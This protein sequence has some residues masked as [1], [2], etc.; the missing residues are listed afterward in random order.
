MNVDNPR[1]PCSRSIP[2]FLSNTPLGLVFGLALALGVPAGCAQ[3]APS[4]IDEATGQRVI[5]VSSV[6]QLQDALQTVEGPTR[7]LIEPGR[8]G[9]VEL[10]NIAAAGGDIEIA[11]ADPDRRAL[12]AGLQLRN[13]SGLT[14][15]DIDL[16]RHSNHAREGRYLLLLVSSED[17]TIEGLEFRGLNQRID[18]SI[19]AAAMLRSSSNVVFAKNS[20]SY[21]RHGLEM[22][23]LEN[24]A[25][26]FNEFTHMQ[27]DAIRGGGVNNSLLANNVMTEFYPAEGDHP[28]GIQL[29]STNQSEPG[30]NIVIRDNLLVKG[31]GGYAQ[32]IFI[33]DTTDVL[34]FENIEILDNLMIGSLYHGINIT[35][36]TGARIA[37]NEIIAV[38][39]Q[40][41]WIRVNYGNDV[42]MEDNRAESFLV[43]NKRGSVREARNRQTSPSNRN[44]PARIREWVEGRESFAEYRG[45]L[46]TSLMAE[47][48]Q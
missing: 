28:D 46:L 17:V 32:G 9:I 34:P 19:G 3:G 40:R 29:W 38:P 41:S 5:T 37:G 11:S 18:P 13:V 1:P 47:Q 12:L 6:E 43:H 30:R 16:S 15:R 26:R 14:I 42:V 33:R 8:Y 23:E 4:Q 31:N 35:G 27:T 36:V 45:P 48:G 20:F 25:I 39:G 10:R 21:F 44:I 2:S 22:L 7:I 24:A